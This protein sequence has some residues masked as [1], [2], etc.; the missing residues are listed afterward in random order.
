MG[1]ANAVGLISIKVVF[2]VVI[3]SSIIQDSNAH[4]PRDAMAM[5]A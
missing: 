3:T 2:L 4:L 1:Q 5:V